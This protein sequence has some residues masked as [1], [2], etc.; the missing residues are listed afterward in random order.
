MKDTNKL[1]IVI[2]GNFTDGENNADP[3]ILL[4]YL[5]EEMAKKCEFIE[6]STQ[7]SSHYSMSLMLDLTNMFE[8][9]IE[10]NYSGII[11]I[12]GSGVLEEMAYMTDLLW[13]HDEPLIYANLLVRN[14]DGKREGLMNFK[15]S[16]IAAL[17]EQTKGKGVLVCTSAELHEASDVAMFDPI[18]PENAFY[19][20]R[21]TCIGKII[22]DEVIYFREAKRPNFLVRRPEKLLNV[23][24]LW[25]SMGGGDTIISVA[26][27]S[28][29]IDGF[30]LVGFGTGNVPPTWVPNIL[31]IIRASIPVAIVSR[32]PCGNLQENNDYEG[33]YQRLIEMGVISG[34][35]L[36]AYQARIKMILGLSVGLTREGLELYMQN[37]SVSEDIPEL[38]N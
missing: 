14:C 3:Y 16:V 2:A 30:V 1:A 9:L 18:S 26:H 8:T 21:K 12:S 36:N 27:N 34:G 11:V 19:S 17:S 10:Q 23:E 4:N 22:N 32:C 25:A 29:K 5:P 15:S 33:G 28:R 7:P 13:K 35:T 20:P 6:W 37:K 38:Y 31:N 24:L